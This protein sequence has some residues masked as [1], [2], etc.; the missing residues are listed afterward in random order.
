MSLLQAEDSERRKETN[1]VHP[2]DGDVKDPN[3]V[4]VDEEMEERSTFVISLEERFMPFN[5]V[6][7][8]ESLSG[9][10]IDET[11]LN[12]SRKNPLVSNST[13]CNGAKP[14]LLCRS[15]QCERYLPGT[16]TI[17]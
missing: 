15:T 14:D 6:E 4:E 8:H 11:S 12:S 1:S 13:E 5:L 10:N 16:R 9:G 3:S 17:G 7:L 2:E